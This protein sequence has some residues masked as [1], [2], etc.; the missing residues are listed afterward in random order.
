[1]VMIVQINQS[2]ISRKN[3]FKFVQ[4]HW[5]E[6]RIR[7]TLDMS[8]KIGLQTNEDYQRS[9]SQLVNELTWLGSKSSKIYV[10]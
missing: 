2:R 10:T 4:P 9:D 7:Y 6:I 5:S 3:V 1:M 8:P